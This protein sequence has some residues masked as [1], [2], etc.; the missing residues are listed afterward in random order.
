MTA[1]VVADEQ[2]HGH[3]AA[4]ATDGEEVEGSDR[5]GASAS[6]GSASTSASGGATLEEAV[7]GG[8]RGSGDR[9][10]GGDGG[11]E[12]AAVLRKPRGMSYYGPPGTSLAASLAA[13][14][15]VATPAEAAADGAEARP[16]RRNFS[17][18]RTVDSAAWQNRTHQVKEAEIAKS[19][20]EELSGFLQLRAGAHLADV[21]YGWAHAIAVVVCCVSRVGEQACLKSSASSM[22]SCFYALW[23]TSRN[24][25]VALQPG[26]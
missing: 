7:A 11:G 1:A 6:R 18:S 4:R 15:Q 10:G 19:L 26:L 3:G 13:A 24:A 21:R 25:Y 12:Q 5:V 20:D 17:V 8:G 16:V 14:Q 2:L 22:R 23:Q 9:E